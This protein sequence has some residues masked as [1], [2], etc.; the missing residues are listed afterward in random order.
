MASRQHQYTIRQI[1]AS[2]DQA[3]RRRAGRL[4]R[5]LNQIALDALAREAGVEGQP[6]RFADLD[7]FFGSWVRDPAVDRALAEQRLVDET[8]WK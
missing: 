5:S 2:V 6:E 3:L 4:G 8:L 7:R 1:P